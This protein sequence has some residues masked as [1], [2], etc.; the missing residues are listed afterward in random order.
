MCS[1]NLGKNWPP[2]VPSWV[3][4]HLPRSHRHP[5]K[6]V[7]ERVSEPRDFP[8]ALLPFFHLKWLILALWVSTQLPPALACSCLSLL[9]YTVD[10]LWIP[11]MES[12]GPLERLTRIPT[13]SAAN[14]IASL[15]ETKFQI[16]LPFCCQLDLRGNQLLRALNLACTVA[17][18]HRGLLP[19]TNAKYIVLPLWLHKGLASSSNNYSGFLCLL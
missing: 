9:Q 7:T 18:A 10:R 19:G 12:M 2:F 14:G 17:G 15:P 8:G 1:L 13:L 16:P 11:F 6:S 4:L 5:I 3:N